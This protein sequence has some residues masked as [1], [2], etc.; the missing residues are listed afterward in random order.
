MENAGINDGDIII[1]DKSLKP[2]NDSVLVCSIDGE[3]TLK[4]FKKVDNKTG[5]L[6]PEN[7][8]FKPIKVDTGQ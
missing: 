6:M 7:P 3:F 5:Y 1:V 4:R 8:K 2:K